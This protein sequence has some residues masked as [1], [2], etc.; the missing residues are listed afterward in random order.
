MI[1]RYVVRD[2]KKNLSEET[3]YQVIKSPII[4]EKS[5]MGRENGQYFFTV[6]SWATKFFIKQ[7]VEKI[8]DVKVKSTNT[9]TVKGKA[10]RFKGRPG[11]RSDTKKAMISL[12]EGYSIDL[13]NGGLR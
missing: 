10:L 4:T 11:T 9:V 12:E 6:E 2:R 1:H 5:T 3:L 13:E 7:A 8:F